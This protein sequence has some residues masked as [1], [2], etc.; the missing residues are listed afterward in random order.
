MGDFESV[1]IIFAVEGRDDWNLRILPLDLFCDPCAQERTVD[2]QDIE[3]DF[4]DSLPE[5]PAPVR[6][7]EPV[8]LPGN[9]NAAVIQN[10]QII[11]PG[12]IGILRRDIIRCMPFLFQRLAVRPA[13]PSYAVLHGGKRFCQ[14]TDNHPCPPCQA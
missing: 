10:P 9:L 6:H 2:V 1:V 7:A 3:G 14:F 11:E 12:M 13:Y 5:F 8:V 4:P